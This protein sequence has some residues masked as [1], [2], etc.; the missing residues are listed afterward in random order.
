MPL[1]SRST[2]DAESRVFDL[3]AQFPVKAVVLLVERVAELFE[4]HD[5]VGI[6]ARMLSFPYDRAENL[7][8]I[9]HVEVTAHHQVA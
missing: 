6:D 2:N 3:V 5:G 7:V 9:C 8:D 1:G 4:Q